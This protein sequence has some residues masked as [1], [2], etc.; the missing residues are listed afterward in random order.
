MTSGGPGLLIYPP[1]AGIGAL[2]A[3]RVAVTIPGHRV[4]KVTTT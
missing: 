4:A 2:L 3:I 1:Y